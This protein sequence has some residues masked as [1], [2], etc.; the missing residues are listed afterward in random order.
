[1]LITFTTILIGFSVVALILLLLA[2]VSFIPSTQKTKLALLSCTAL[3]ATLV[4]LQLLHLNHLEMG[5]DLFSS[6]TYLTLLMSTPPAFYLFSRSILQPTNKPKILD[7]VHLLPIATV[8]LLPHSMVFLIAFIVGASYSAWLSTV[9]YGMRQHVGRFRFEMFFFCLFAGLAVAILALV[10][11]VPWVGYDFF[12]TAYALSISACVILVTFAII[13]FPD[14]L[15]DVEETARSAY[16]ASTLTGMDTK[17]ILDK[18]NRLFQEEQ[19]H[20]NENLNLS[21]ISEQIDCTTHQTSELINSHFQM[22][23]SRFVR[24]Q[25]VADAKQL[26][27]TDRK[28][29]ALSVGLTVGFGSQSSFYAAFREIVGESPAAYRKNSSTS[30]HSS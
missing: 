3:T 23:F 30:V 10:I 27:I 21:V 28:A 20:R 1:M 26:L 15:A 7:L 9:V 17:P 11:S 16:V 5:K 2:Y 8:F 19:I 6:L 22:G 18:L 12:F 25:R 14:I 29:S 24:E 4:G 13:A